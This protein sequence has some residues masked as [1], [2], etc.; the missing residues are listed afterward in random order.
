MKK[1]IR[2]QKYRNI[3]GP[4]NKKSMDFFVLIIFITIPLSSISQINHLDSIKKAFYQ[5]PKVLIKLD[6]KYSFVS[7]Q[8]VTM[9]GIK[10]GLNFD[11]KVKLGIGYSWM[12]NN[13]KFDNPTHIVNNINHNLRYSYLSIFG[14]YNFY[15][16]NIWSYMVNLDLAI[17]KLGYKNVK[18]KKYK[19]KSLGT[20]LE[21]SII[22][23]YIQIKYLAIGIGG[24]YR[25]VFR[26]DNNIVEKF[27]A[28]IFILRLKLDF[29][30][31][32]KEL[33]KK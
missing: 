24:G 5:K 32:Y 33:I 26:E 1:S 11:N 2:K 19:Y 3:K 15:T 7:N 22:A 17:V 27:S 6:S 8:L 13:F 14:D 4:Y 18:T 31:I 10:T 25:F 12:K 16:T 29:Y 9:R 23:E 21:P 20:V 30:T 28:P